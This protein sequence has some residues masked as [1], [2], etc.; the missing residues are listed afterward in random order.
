MDLPFIHYQAKRLTQPYYLNK[1]MNG[2]QEEMTV[3]Q[4]F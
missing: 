4:M 3:P 2:T 1:N